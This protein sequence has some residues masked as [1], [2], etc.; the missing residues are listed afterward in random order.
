MCREETV[1]KCTA[2]LGP[3]WHAS[4]PRVTF[5]MCLILKL[6][7]LRVIKIIIILINYYVKKY[8][9]RL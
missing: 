9:L 4:L 5:D 1:S 2:V 6:L 8:D 7:H 3:H